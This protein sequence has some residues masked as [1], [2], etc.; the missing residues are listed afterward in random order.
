[1]K[2]EK[3]LKNKLEELEMKLSDLRIRFKNTDS[4]IMLDQL[5]YEITKVDSEL[6]ILKWVLN[7]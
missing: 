7:N 3:A 1:M 4:Q 2:S 5:Q 6:Q